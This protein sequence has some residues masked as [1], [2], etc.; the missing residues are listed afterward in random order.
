MFISQIV[1][2]SSCT[3]RKISPHLLPR[4]KLAKKSCLVNVNMEAHAGMFRK[5]T[6][7]S[8]EIGN[9]NRSFFKQN[10]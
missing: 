5:R 8:P 2:M 3:L 7:Q 1:Q 4:S 6:L 10:K 9:I